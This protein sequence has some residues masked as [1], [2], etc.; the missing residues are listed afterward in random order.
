MICGMQDESTTDHEKVKRVPAQNV[1]EESLQPNTVSDGH[2]KPRDEAKPHAEHLWLFAAI[3][4]AVFEF[5]LDVRISRCGLSS[6]A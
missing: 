2:N 4:D 1:V 6:A 5:R 3:E